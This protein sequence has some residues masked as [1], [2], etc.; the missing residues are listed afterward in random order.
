MYDRVI[1]IETAALGADHPSTANTLHDK[2]N[3][4]VQMG[5]SA[6]L[7]AAV[8]LY[9]RVIEIRTA[10]LGADHPSTANTLHEKASALVQM[11]G[12]ANLAAAVALYNRVV[13]ILS[14]DHPTSVSARRLQANVLALVDADL[15]GTVVTT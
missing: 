1:D 2:A 13:E 3:A 11:G 7:A 6:N 4:L 9:D 14:A 10:A 12:S 15:S 5:G 8:A